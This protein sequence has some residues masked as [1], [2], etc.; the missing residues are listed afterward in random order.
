MR[1][2]LIILTVLAALGIVVSGQGRNLSPASAGWGLSRLM[3]AMQQVKAANALFV[4]RRYLSMLSRPIETSGRLSYFAPDKLRK[5]TLSPTAG[6]LIVDGGK[7]TIEEGPG[8]NSRTLSLEEYPQLGALVEAIRATLAGDLPSLRR[9]FDVSLTGVPA[10]WQLRLEPQSSRL[11]DFIRSI[12]IG[13]SE[14][15]IRSVETTEGDGDHSEMSVV[16]DHQ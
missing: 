16:A 2:P 9:Y 12:R 6:L 15:E 11:R 8:G 1:L 14:Q 5:Q 3:T 10:D 7:L 4:E 13:G